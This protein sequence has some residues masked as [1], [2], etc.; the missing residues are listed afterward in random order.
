V[1]NKPLILFLALLL[2]PLAT[3]QAAEATPPNILIIL[4][5][6]MGWGDPQ[7]FNPQSKI[8]TSD[9]RTAA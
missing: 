5:D 6:D 9:I 2:A 1:I 7:C 4:V 8:T 3:L